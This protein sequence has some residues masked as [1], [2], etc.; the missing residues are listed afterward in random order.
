MGEGPSPDHRGTMISSPTTTGSL[1]PHQLSATEGSRISGRGDTG[2]MKTSTSSDY[3]GCLLETQRLSLL[4]LGVLS[5][6]DCSPELGLLVNP[7]V[8]SEGSNR[9]RGRKKRDF[10]IHTW[11]N[12]AQN[13]WP[14]SGSSQLS[15]PPGSSAS[16]NPRHLPPALHLS[17]HQA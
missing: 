13:P 1:L 8:T 2:S 14:A 9:E 6:S 5:T 10:P 4:P 12:P 17:P 3:L 11:G 15:V 16:P 7:R